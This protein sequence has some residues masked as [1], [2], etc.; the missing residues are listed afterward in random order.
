MG[1]LSEEKKQSSDRGLEHFNSS[2]CT[3]LHELWEDFETNEHHG[4]ELE[5]EEEEA[6]QA[7]AYR[8]FNT[9]GQAATVEMCFTI[10]G[11]LMKVIFLTRHP[12][13]ERILDLDQHHHVSDPHGQSR[14]VTVSRTAQ[15]NWSTVRAARGLLARA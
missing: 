10:I 5:V 15:Q 8:L 2:R 7:S 9:V 6:A 1:F 14:V 13:S 11:V 3:E 12:N 4:L